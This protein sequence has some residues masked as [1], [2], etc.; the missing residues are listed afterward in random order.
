[1]VSTDKIISKIQ[2]LLAMAEDTSSPNEAMIAANRARILMDKHQLSKADIENAIG[3]QFA[4]TH[5]DKKTKTAQSW[6]KALAA[7]VAKLNDCRAVLQ[8]DGVN[9]YKFQGFKSDA[10][11]AK[12]TMDYLIESCE[13]GCLNSGAKGRSEKNFF[14]LGFVKSITSRID[15]IVEKRNETFVDKQ[16][17]CSL[18][19]VKSEM[20]VSHFGALGS[21]RP[22][23]MR[24]PNSAGSSAYIDGL[25]HGKKTGLEKQVKGTETPKLSV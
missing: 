14:R 1:V 6:L 8:W 2:K 22:A 25:N 5:A 4:E 9:F 19:P 17:G 3:D 13:R 20:I 10:I 11:V 7:T 12:L 21:A 23:Q 18:I 24:P 15:E 16:T